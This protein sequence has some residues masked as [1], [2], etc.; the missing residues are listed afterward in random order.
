MTG[1]VLYEVSNGVARITL[2]RPPVNALDLEMIKGVIKALESAAKDE[3]TRA[4]V[5]TSAIPNRFCAGLD[6]NIML[7][8]S[9]RKVRNLLQ[10]LYVHLHDAQ[11]NLGKPSIAAVAGA[12]RGGGMI[13]NRSCC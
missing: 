8:T 5:L 7:G 2:K 6:L 9:E 1:T 3:E 10:E 4:V 13:E 12:A 11:Y